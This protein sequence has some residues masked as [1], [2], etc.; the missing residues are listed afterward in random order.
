MKFTE[1]MRLGAMMH[2]QTYGQSYDFEGETKI[3]ASCAWG[4]AVVGGWPAA[5]R[6]YSKTPVGCPVCKRC[7][8]HNDVTSLVTHLNDDHRWTREAIA[9]HVDTLGLEVDTPVVTRPEEVLV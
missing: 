8:A 7:V 5:D 2:P 9:D 3:V 1:A 6:I 4:A